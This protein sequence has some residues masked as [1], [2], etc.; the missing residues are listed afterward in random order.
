VEDDPIDAQAIKRALQD[1]SIA[2]TVVH[3]P[4]AR[5][6]LACLR[7]PGTDRPV[8]IL[9][10]LHMPGTDGLEFLHVVKNDPWLRD[11]PIVVLTASDEPRD[12]V[13]SFDL[14]IAGYMVKSA[15]Y[16]GLRETIRTILDYWSLSQLPLHHTGYGS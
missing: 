10:D 7:S 14:G 5:E 16:E 9:L 2:D 8:L 13:Q 15:Q 3:V 1:S 12:I 11:I 4:C 6:A